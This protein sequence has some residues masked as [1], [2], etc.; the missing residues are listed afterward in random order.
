P[1]SEQRLDGGNGNVLAEKAAEHRSLEP[2]PTP[3]SLSDGTYSKAAMLGIESG[4]TEA[5]LPGPLPTPSWWGEG[6]A[7][8]T[9]LKMPAVVPWPEAVD[10]KVLLDALVHVLR[11]FVVLP[12]WVA[13]TLALWILHTYAFELRDVTTYLGIESP[14]KR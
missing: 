7:A 14:E 8:H 3:S 1:K 9:V 12:K 5:P 6:S 2:L 11:R 13:E 10:G 4:K